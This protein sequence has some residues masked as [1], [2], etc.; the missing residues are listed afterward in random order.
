MEDHRSD[1]TTVTDSSRGGAAPPPVNGSDAGPPIGAQPSDIDVLLLGPVGVRVGDGWSTPG[2]GRLR[3]ILSAFALADGREVSTDTLTTLLWGDTQPA[4]STLAVAVHRLRKWLAGSAGSAATIRTT[5]NGYAL[6]LTAGSTDVARFRRLLADA[7][8]RPA[9]QAAPLLA[10][11]LALWRGDPLADVPS[12]YV[13][14]TVVAQLQRERVAATLDYGR[15]LLVT[16]RARAAVDVLGPLVEQQPFEE[17]AHGVLMEAL[18]AAGRQA[19]ALEVYERLRARLADKLGVD[20]G[21]QMREAHLR[22]LRQETPEATDGPAA[23]DLPMQLP[24]ATPVFSGRRAALSTL[25]EALT[26]PARP[27]HQAAL[28]A[29]P[30]AVTA[31]GSARVALLYGMPGVG[32]TALAVQLAHRIRDR[33]PDGQL[34][35]ELRGVTRPRR[36]AAVIVTSRQRLVELVAR[37]HLVEPM[38]EDE[39][40]DVLG[41][42]LTSERVARE[43]TAAREIARACGGL[44]LALR[45][46]TARLLSQ[47]DMWI[48]DAARILRDSRHRLR[49]LHAGRLT[50][51]ASFESSYRALS[52]PARRA[53]RRLASLPTPS[54]PQWAVAVAAGVDSSSQLIGEL[55]ESQLVTPVRRPAP[56]QARYAFHDLVRLFA[57]EP[58]ADDPGA[59][60]D[61]LVDAW[62]ALASDASRRL[63]TRTLDITRLHAAMPCPVEGVVDDLPVWFDEEQANLI[64]VL[65]YA[66]ASGWPRRAAA[67]L[68]ALNS[69]FVIRHAVDEW[70]DCA[71][72]VERVASAA[73]DRLALAYVAESRVLLHIALDQL[74]E[75]ARQAEAAT[76]LFTELNDEPG[77]TQMRYHL[78]FAYRR[79]GDID[80]ALRLTTELTE[81]YLRLGDPFGQAAAHN[82]L[83]VLYHDHLTDLDRSQDHF[84]RAYALLEGVEGRPRRQVGFSLGSLHLDRG[85][86]AQAEVLLVDA[87]ARARDDNDLVGIAY[88]LHRLG[89]AWIELDRTAEARSALEESYGLCRR[90]GK[91]EGEAM[92][93][94]ALAT[95]DE[96]VGVPDGGAGRLRTAADIYAALNLPSDL[97]RVRARLDLLHQ[98]P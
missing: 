2:S 14:E 32:K 75:V 89:A 59:P 82:A 51:R 26:S 46:A 96:R 66:C 4:S 71:E 80:S 79:L 60:V 18:A 93:L 69:Y 72:A 16:G 87:L 23:A 97:R 55:A 78:A 8:E 76:A 7:R 74:D 90:I 36:A 41:A 11:A 25:A 65:R 43:A 10:R 70:R 88:I 42:Y 3:A 6:D 34:F 77:A 24:A 38:T 98:G 49:E 44:P 21:P 67:L 68:T 20:P 48:A 85:R 95:L 22:V 63:G 40:I 45:I 86:A 73:G 29:G 39:S 57:V 31:A 13:D 81:A 91:R 15:A 53:F 37:R 94:E 62:C 33:H 35:A 61:A 5:T 56:G 54:F 64:E 50:V 47:P 52:L 30:A 19:D 58:S 28:P 12:R 92:A 27:V 83:G 1:R 9:S 17:G 84:E